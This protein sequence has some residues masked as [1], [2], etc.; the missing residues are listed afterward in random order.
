MSAFY[1]R[2]GHPLTLE[3]WAAL[4]DDAPNREALTRVARTA[5]GDAW[6]STVWLG[7]DHSFGDG[8]APLI[9]E[10]MVFGGPLDQETWR[11]ATEEQARAGHEHAVTLA[12][13]EAAL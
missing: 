5:V 6:V 1:D 10:T 3:E 8:Q 4:L 13:L 7:I 11:Y 12:R 2:Q 9:F